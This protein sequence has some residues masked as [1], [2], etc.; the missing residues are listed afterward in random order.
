MK[1]KMMSVNKEDNYREKSKLNKRNAQIKKAFNIDTDIAIIGMACR[2]P[3]ALNYEEFGKNLMREINSIKE[4]PPNRWDP[5]KYYSPN[6]QEPNK[7]ISKWCGLVDNIEQFDNQFF[8][9]S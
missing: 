8:D 6:S 7:S 5:H 2:F 4:I 9:I 1:E 3:G